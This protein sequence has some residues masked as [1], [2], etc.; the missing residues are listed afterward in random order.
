MLKMMT[1]CLCSILSTLT[2]FFCIKIISSLLNFT[3]TNISVTSVDIYRELPLSPSRLIGDGTVN[4]WPH[5]T[6]TARNKLAAT[7]HC[8]NFKVVLLMYMAHNCLC[9]LYISE[10]LAPISSTSMHWQLCSSGSSNYTIP[11][12]RT[13]FGHRAF[14]VA[15]PVIWNSIT[16]FIRAADNVQTFKW[17]VYS[18]RTVSTFLT[19]LINSTVTLL[20][21]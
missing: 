7:C 2:Q 15:V 13:K 20:L 16:E 5:W 4:S 18:K 9:P 21:F 19:D 6:C 11:R 14:S 17:N 1:L 10:V 12:T 3:F 8:I